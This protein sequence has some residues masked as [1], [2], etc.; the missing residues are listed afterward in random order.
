MIRAAANALEDP[1]KGEVLELI[2]SAEFQSL[3]RS[4]A[5]VNFCKTNGIVSN[6]I[7]L[8][9]SSRNQNLLFVDREPSWEG[10]TRRSIPG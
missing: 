6:G 1:E 10:E 4:D 2:H 9:V 5:Q 8:F 7:Q 3:T